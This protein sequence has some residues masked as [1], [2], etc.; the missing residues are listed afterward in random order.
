MLN[1]IECKEEKMS[2]I[3]KIELFQV[4]RMVFLRTVS[5]QA[6][7]QLLQ[8]W[9]TTLPKT[10]RGDDCKKFSSVWKDFLTRLIFSI[11]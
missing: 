1:E 9:E 10:G 5:S 7:P 4:R 3:E 11:S 2:L 6:Y 8:N